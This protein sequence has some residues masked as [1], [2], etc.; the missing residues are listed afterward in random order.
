MKKNCFISKKEPFEVWMRK[1][2]AYIGKYCGFSA[3]DLP[4]FDYWLAWDSD[5]SPSETAKDVIRAA[6]DY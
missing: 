3:D 2:N 5:I 4:D 6:R 1:V